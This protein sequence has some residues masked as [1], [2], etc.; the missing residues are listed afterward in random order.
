MKKNLF[1]MFGFGVSVLFGACS[2]NEVED[3]PIGKAAEGVVCFSS[4]NN[5]ATRTSLNPDGTLYWTAGDYIFVKNGSDYVPSNNAA[6]SRVARENFYLTGVFGDETYPVVYAGNGKNTAAQAT[7]VEIK[8]QQAQTVA[9]N[10]DHLGACGDCGNA[11][12]TRTSAGNYTFDIVHRAAYFVIAPRH[13]FDGQ[14]VTLQKV[15]VTTSGTDD[16]CGTY[17][18]DETTTTLKGNLSSG[19]KKTITLTTSNFA[20]PTVDDVAGDAAR[21]AD[22]RSYM[23]LQPGTHTLTF[24]YYVTVNGTAREFTKT[25]TEREFKAGYFTNVKHV[26]SDSRFNAAGHVALSPEDD[27]L[28][29][30]GTMAEGYYQWGATDTYL[31]TWE[32]DAYDATTVAPTQLTGLLWN[33]LPNANELYSYAKYGDPHWDNT[34]A[35]SLDGGLTEYTGGIWLKKKQYISEFSSTVGMNGVDMRSTEKTFYDPLSSGKP[36]DSVID[37]YFFLPAAGLYN[38]QPGYETVPVSQGS[39]G[40]YWSSSPY[41]G[42]TEMV[43]CLIF[44]SDSYDSYVGVESAHRSNGLYAAPFK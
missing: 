3:N 38:G 42:N 9:D 10:A 7:S 32:S 5:E 36:D 35:W 41:P 20:V 2:Q 23:V 18:F 11:T 39:E 13:T 43:Y 44:Y 4:G 14:T 6:T 31:N 37:Q 34:T 40:C 24:K 27:I 12:A 8:D 29:D 1:L 19:G 15:E 22:A 16:L 33:D 26:L 25:V 30:A 21:F 17:N 28:D